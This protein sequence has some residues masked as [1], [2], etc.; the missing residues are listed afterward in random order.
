M[1]NH[2]IRTTLMAA[3]GLVGALSLAACGE[4]ASK[5]AE[6]KAGDQNAVV[7]AAQD[8]AGAATGVVTGA[9]AGLG[10]EAFTKEAAIAGAYEI[11]SARIAIERTKNAEVKKLATTL[12][13][14]HTKAGKALVMLAKLEKT[15]PLPEELDSRRQGLLDNLK[16]ASDADFDKVY[17][18]QQEAA[19]NETLMAF[20]AY[21][22]R[23]DNADLKAFAVKTTP[24][25]QEHADM[26]KALEAART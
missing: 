8:A 11:Q 2:T 23:G 25:L 12:L 4:P 26:V 3:A 13:E 15:Q 16:A 6:A 24:R 10:T 5:S 17:L 20:K 21:G 9:T 14:D 1:R 19:H 22:E 7:N 18:K